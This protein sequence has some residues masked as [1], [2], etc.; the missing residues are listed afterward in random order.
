M[1]D[2]GAR[3][4]PIAFQAQEDFAR[5]RRNAFVE[6]IGAFL[7][8]RPDEL[9]SFEQ[10]RRELPIQGQAYRGVEAIPLAKIAGSLDRYEDFTRHFYPTQTHTQGCWENVDRA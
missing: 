4:K 10:V 8:R 6:Q 7:L 3:S 9:L 1:I 5:A 2:P